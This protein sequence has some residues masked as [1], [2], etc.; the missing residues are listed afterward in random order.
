MS[1]LNEM[2][3]QTPGKSP[4]QYKFFIV[5]TGHGKH[6]SKSYNVSVNVWEA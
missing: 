5:N 3:I 6:T 4:Q 1:I 2:K